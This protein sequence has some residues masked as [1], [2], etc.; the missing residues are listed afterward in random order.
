MFL[1]TVGFDN[2]YHYKKI[3]FIL[4]WYQLSAR[5]QIILRNILIANIQRRKIWNFLNTRDHVYKLYNLKKHH[6]VDDLIDFVAI[7]SDSSEDENYLN[8]NRFTTKKC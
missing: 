7:N 1:T 6:D 2:S 3:K 8:F 5:S 4:Y